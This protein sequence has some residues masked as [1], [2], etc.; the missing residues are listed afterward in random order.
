MRGLSQ[1]HLTP[2]RSESSSPYGTGTSSS[3]RAKETLKNVPPN[4]SSQGTFPRNDSRTAL[5]KLAAKKEEEDRERGRNREE[6][7]GREKEKGRGAGREGQ[8]D[9][10]RDLQG[11]KVGRK[12]NIR[13]DFDQ[14]NLDPES[15]RSRG[16]CGMDV[17]LEDDLEKDIEREGEEEGEGEGEGE[18]VSVLD[19]SPSVSTSHSHRKASAF[20]NALSPSNQNQHTERERERE[21]EDSLNSFP[22]GYLD[23]H[24]G[25][26]S[27]RNSFKTPRLP[28]GVALRIEIYSTWGDDLFVGLNGLDIFDENGVLINSNSSTKSAIK[29]VFA[30]NRDVLIPTEFQ[31]DPREVSNLMNGTNFTRNDLHVWLAPLGSLREKEINGGDVKLSKNK[32]LDQNCDQ[33]DNNDTDNDIEGGGNYRDVI[34]SVTITFSHPV[35]LSLIRVFNY[36]KSRTHCTRGV[37]ECSLFLDDVMIFEG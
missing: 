15:M 26:N 13:N 37:R 29:N 23:P 24:S 35:T 27:Y 9:L 5:K 16:D 12:E 33:Y 36:N 7:S 17:T 22:A 3:V 21:L 28:C 19:P 20:E 1:G 6:N 4:S 11:M 10:D 8:F 25:I 2:T 18:E 34:T 32:K 14:R 30:D 31:N